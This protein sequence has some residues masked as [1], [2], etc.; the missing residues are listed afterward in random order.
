MQD[1]GLLLAVPLG[2]W[3]LA[4]P[5]AGLV[6]ALVAGSAWAGALLVDL[7]WRADVPARQLGALRGRAPLPVPRLIVT[8]RGPVLE[9]GRGLYELGDWPEGMAQSFELQVL[10]PGPVRP[11]LPLRIE[12]RSACLRLAVQSDGPAERAGPEPGQVLA[13]PFTL[14]TLAAG[15]GGEVQVKGTPR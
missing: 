2:T 5:V 10:N 8:L 11:Q 4:G 3:L 7:R 15:A 1:F 9:R 12:V 13:H 6:I 14:R